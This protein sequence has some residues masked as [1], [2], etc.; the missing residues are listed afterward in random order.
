M[1][2]QSGDLFRRNG[3]LDV[4]FWLDLKLRKS[5]SSKSRL[6]KTVYGQNIDQYPNSCYF[7]SLQ[8]NICFIFSSRSLLQDAIVFSVM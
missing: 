5:Y 1:H 4:G 7:Y 6:T 8:V 2:E 3:S